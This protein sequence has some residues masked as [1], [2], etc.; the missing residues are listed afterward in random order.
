MYKVFIALIYH[1]LQKYY[2]GHFLPPSSLFSPKYLL[3]IHIK[4][5]YIRFKIVIDVV[6]HK[7]L[8]P[9]ILI[10]SIAS[11]LKSCL[12]TYI[13]L[14][15]NNCGLKQSLT[16]KLCE[17]SLHYMKC[18]FHYMKTHQSSKKDTTKI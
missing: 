14:Y 3:K 9:G 10:K 12:F 8:L 16:I 2:K 7:V 17:C 6:F 4:Y 15:E 11:L 18:S 13:L 5:L 1:C